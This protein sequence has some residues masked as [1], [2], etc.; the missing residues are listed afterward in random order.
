M[1]LLTDGDSQP[2]LRKANEYGY[3]TAGLMLAP[4]LVG[5]RGN[6]CPDST[7]ECRRHCLAFSGRG[8][9]GAVITARRKRTQLW[10]D[11]PDQFLALL[12]ADL[13]ALIRKAERRG[14]RPA[15]RLNT[16][17]DI[18]W[19][20]TDVIENFPEIQ[21]YDYTK[22]VKRARRF[23]NGLLPSNYHLTLSRSELNKPECAAFLRAGGTV[24]SVFD[25]L[26]RGPHVVDGDVHDLTFLHPPGSLIA[27]SPKGSLI[28]AD[29]PFK[30]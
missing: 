30:A 16:L 1:H 24:S 15:C 22:S 9:M 17:S 8:G 2:K 28:K 5:Q 13:E 10:F 3:H 14:L 12:D 11:D 26:P 18:P 6:V 29:S 23:L 4:H 27:L 21:F 7:P 19:E 20:E 25:R